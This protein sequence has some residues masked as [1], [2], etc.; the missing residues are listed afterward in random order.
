MCGGDN[1]AAWEEAADEAFVMATL[2]VAQPEA[3][4]RMVMTTAHN[5]GSEEA[6]ALFFV[7]CTNSAAHA[8]TEFWCWP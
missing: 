1:P 3:S 6:V 2:N 5:A 7:S 4:E 8:F